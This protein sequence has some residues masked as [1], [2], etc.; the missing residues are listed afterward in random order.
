MR[1]LSIGALAVVV[2]ALFACEDQPCNRYVDY[3][4][5]CHADDPDFDCQEL[6]NTLIG[7][8]PAVQDQC[9]IDLADQQAIDDQAGLACDVDPI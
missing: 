2:G 8:D 7:A 9:S 5:Q 4:C 6:T 3:I 1:V